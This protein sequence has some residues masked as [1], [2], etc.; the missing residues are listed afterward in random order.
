MSHKT[1]YI[2]CP[3]SNFA[4]TVASNDHGLL[5][6]LQD[7]NTGIVTS[8]RCKSLNDPRTR[9]V[10]KGPLSHS[11]LLQKTGRKLP[12]HSAVRNVHSV[13]PQWVC[14]RLFLI[15]LR[16][17]DGSSLQGYNSPHPKAPVT[18]P[19][20]VLDIVLEYVATHPG[21]NGKAK[22]IAYA[23]VAT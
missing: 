10:L 9:S 20:G 12:S 13:P 17:S 1:M 15:L 19:R 7:P 14:H 23:L 21:C 6:K 18:L 8:Q 16:V 4:F 22:L 5:L 11:I 2:S 3:E